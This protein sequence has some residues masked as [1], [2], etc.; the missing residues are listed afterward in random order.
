[1]LF[2]IMRYLLITP[3]KSSQLPIEVP[4]EIA[5]QPN[6]TKSTSKVKSTTFKSSRK[7]TKRNSIKSKA[8]KIKRSKQ[9]AKSVAK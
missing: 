3:D 9:V 2:T 7:A 5:I 4:N 8:R 6:Q 1:M